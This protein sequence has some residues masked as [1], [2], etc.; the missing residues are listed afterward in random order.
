MAKAAPRYAKALLE[1]LSS[2]GQLEKTLPLA[3]ALAALP[4]EL[5]S[6]LSDATVPVQ[7]R[8]QA[9]LSA[10][11]NPSTD[12]VMG[13]FV[14]LLAQRRRLGEISEI[15]ASLVSQFELRSGIVRGTVFAKSPLS[16]IQIQTLEKSLSRSRTGSKVELSQKS[17]ES[18]LGGFRVRLGDNVL[19]ATANNQLNQ[20]RR[21]LL[22]A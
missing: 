1:T 19:D 16:S 5:A 2:S 21:A 3:K 10:I 8:T 4:P 14:S 11:G 15:A 22:S 13:R 20:A 9:L 7:K 18:I 6:R 17:D 12:S